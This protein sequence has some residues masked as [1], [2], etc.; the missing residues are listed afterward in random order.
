MML[1]ILLPFLLPCLLGAQAP[2]LKTYDLAP[3]LFDAPVDILPDAGGYTLL[4][5]QTEDDST[6]AG[7]VYLLRLDSD[8][9]QTFYQTYGLTGSHETAASLVAATGGGWT[10]AGSK[11]NRGW[12]VRIGATGNVVWASEL[13]LPGVSNIA[14]NDLARLPDGGYFAVGQGRVGV[15]FRLLAARFDS[16]G[17]LKW[18]RTYASSPAMALCTTYYGTAAI[19]VSRDK[20]H[21]I[22]ALNGDLSWEKT[23]TPPE[24]GPDSGSTGISLLDVT[25][26]ADESFAVIGAIFNND[27]S[28]YYSGY[29]ASVWSQTGQFGWE[30]VY[31]STVSPSGASTSDAA[32][33]SYLAN[34]EDIL[35]AGVA[36]GKISVTRI[37]LSGNVL[38]MLDLIEIGDC[39]QPRMCRAGGYFALSAGQQSGGAPNSFFYRSPGNVFSLENNGIGLRPAEAAPRLSPNPATTAVQLTLQTE[40]PRTLTLQLLDAN[41]R[42][43]RNVEWPV[44]PGENRFDWPLGDLMPGLYWL[45]LP[46]TEWPAQM[47]IKN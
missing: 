15:Q 34:A 38:D 25:A 12:L 21:K 35:L 29:Y 33:I 20:I 46:G 8:G 6:G 23:I 10:M 42:P 36:S 30:D 9:E 24:F 22:R 19:V 45:T 11:N 16:G 37:D 47:L 4:G 39:F 18:A 5:N 44:T 17:G 43:V 3:D 27:A 41:R 14:F 13:T 32:T 1:R 28:G 40:T 31:N 26:I 2:V 7:Q